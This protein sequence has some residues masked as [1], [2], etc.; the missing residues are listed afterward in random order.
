MCRCAN[1]AV[2]GPMAC[3][4]CEGEMR[5]KAR[6]DDNHGK[7][8]KELRKAGCSV[9]SLAASGGGVPDLL[10]GIRG[11]NLLLEVKDGDKCPSKRRLTPDQELWH[12]QWRGEVA[13]VESVQDALKTVGLLS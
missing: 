6:V 11:R 5:R 1:E 8:V 10:V 2:A 9:Q 13:V 7:I 3:Q 4:I 12:E